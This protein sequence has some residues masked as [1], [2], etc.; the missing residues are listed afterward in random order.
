MSDFD[1]IQ[2]R[3]VDGGL[4]LIF[5]ELLVRRRAGE[6]ANHLGLSPSAISHALT[7]LRDV[8]GDPLFIRRSHGLEPTK[9]AIELGPR[10][11]AVLELLDKAVSDD[12]GF[13]PA[14]SGRRFRLACWDDVASLLGDRLIAA[15]AAE[16]P[17]A[18]FSVR[19]VSLQR[20][21]RAVRRGEADVAIGV[22][23]E[24]PK[25]FTSEVL[26]DDDYCVIARQ[27]HPQVQGKVDL[28]TYARIGHVLVGDPDGGL[29]DEPPW[30]RDE[31]NAV[32]GVMPAPQVV[33]THAYVPAWETAML[34]VSRSDVL[35]DCPRRLAMRFADRLGLQVLEPPY[36]PFRFQVRWVRR[37]GS[38]DRG[39]D[40][41]IARIGEAAENTG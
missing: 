41:L 8:F 26:Y 25:E 29:A 6:V 3:K 16:A 9:R 14:R 35:A 15:F 32:Y 37:A 36:P 13:D 38:A 40:W 22:F 5:R 39:V 4:L 24:I 11:E 31:I 2:I 12:A 1:S 7:R 28:L 18:S 23:G 17:Q 20:A 21:L 27:G 30:D 10:I 19:H 34:M 33:R